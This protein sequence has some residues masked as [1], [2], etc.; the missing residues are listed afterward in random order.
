M[1]CEIACFCTGNP[2]DWYH[3]IVFDG[4][5]DQ[6]AVRAAKHA[7]RVGIRIQDRTL[8]FRDL[9]DLMEWD[10]HCPTDQ[11]FDFDDGFYRVTVYTTPEGLDSSD[12]IVYLHFE[13]TLV[14]PELRWDGVPQLC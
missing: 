7:I 1:N 4:Q 10:P 9:Y 6:T 8:C 3:L 5:L 11:Q 13:K 14:R 12:R 2:G